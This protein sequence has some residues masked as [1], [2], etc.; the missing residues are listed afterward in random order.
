MN[1][2]LILF[3]QKN[4]HNLY[5]VKIQVYDGKKGIRKTYNSGVYLKKDEWNDKKGVIKDKCPNKKSFDYTLKQKIKEIEKSFNIGNDGVLDDDFDIIKELENYIKELKILKKDGTS[6]NF[7]TLK[8]HLEKYCS[9]IKINSIYFTNINIRFLK[10]LE[11]YFINLY[12]DKEDIDGY[13]STKN[14]F[15]RL[16]GIYNKIKRENQINSINPFELFNLSIKPKEPLNKS[17]DIRTFNKIQSLSISER[18]PFKFLEYKKLTIAKNIF[19]FQTLAQG[20]RVSDVFNITYSDI[21]I[22]RIQ[23]YKSDDIKK[24]KKGDINIFNTSI[25]YKMKKTNKEMEIILFPAMIFVLRLFVPKEKILSYFKRLKELKLKDDEFY[26]LISD[27]QLKNEI[28]KLDIQD[29]YNDVSNKKELVST[30]LTITLQLL[31][32]DEKYKNYFVIQLPKFDKRKYKNELNSRDLFYYLKYQREYYNKYLKSLQSILKI[33]TK[34]SS[35]IARHTYSD[36]LQRTN[37]DV[38]LVSKILGHSNV[39]TTEKYLRSLRTKDLKDTSKELYDDVFNVIK[40][41]PNFFEEY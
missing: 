6:Q 19:V 7:L 22:E 25:Q 13:Y 39:N 26:L 10:N 24:S 23:D 9:D 30:L 36:I 2:N 21:I 38:Y 16:Y 37:K 40:K 28:N 31:K 35:H 27:K 12:N 18:M 14:M 17:L 41:E 4:K 20:M 5:P 15:D 8:N 1:I 11:L 33:E 29:D 32:S 34:L 3:K